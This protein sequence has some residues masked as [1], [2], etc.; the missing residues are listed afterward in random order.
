MSC[1]AIACEAWNNRRGLPNHWLSQ[2]FFSQKFRKSFK[3]EKLRN[4]LPTK[5]FTYT[6]CFLPL[7]V[8]VQLC[9]YFVCS[10]PLERQTTQSDARSRRRGGSSVQG[11]AVTNDCLLWHDR[12]ILFEWYS[13]KNCTIYTSLCSFYSMLKVTGWIPCSAKFHVLFESHAFS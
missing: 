8:S 5:N 7:P 12:Q 13:Q 4:L 9:C 3:I 10:L 11:M 1:S 2:I 6:V